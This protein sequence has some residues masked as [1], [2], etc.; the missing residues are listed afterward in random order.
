MPES[1][2]DRPT[3][4]HEHIFLLS[5][6]GSTLLWYHKRFKKWAY[7]KPKPHWARVKPVMTYGEG[8]NSRLHQDRDPRHSSKRKVRK[9]NWVNLWSGR[10]YYY[11]A[12]AIKESASPDSHARYAR[13]RSDTHKWANGGPGNQTI[14]KSFEHMRKPQGSAAVKD[15]VDMRNKRSVWTVAT[16]P[17]PE[18]HFATFPEDL[19]K[20]CILA[21]APVGGVVFDPFAGSGTTVKVAQDLGRVG[22]GLD[23]KPEYSQMAKKRSAQMGLSIG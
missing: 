19:I 8:K 10:D 3:K 22:I 12:E 20:P 17:Y 15:V 1:V 18:A 5:K 23:L 4:S 9:A 7:E 2:T 14:A 21:G 6:S 16:Q 11:D 13:G